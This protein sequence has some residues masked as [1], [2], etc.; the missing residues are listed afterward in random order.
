MIFL[1]RDDLFGEERL[2]ELRATIGTPDVQSLN[3][4]NLDGARLTVGE[5][6]T[7]VETFPFLSERRL[8]IVR[9]LFGA[10]SRGDADGEG[11]TRRG[12][13]DAEREREFLAYIPLVPPF[14]DLVLVV[15]RDVKT[16]HPV[17]K[18]VREAHGEVH[19]VDTPVG[20]A[21]GEWIQNRVRSK[22]GRVD[23]AAIAELASITVDDLRELDQT[24]ESLAIYAAERPIAV[25]DVRA[26]VRRS[27]ESSVF[28]RTR[29]SPRAT[30]LPLL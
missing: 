13:V 25:E 1:I 2:A 17:A 7:V 27:R 24:L 14:T 20:D 18:A 22:G 6:R 5:L 11:D 23:S 26:L 10:A 30:T 16:N 4:A 8:V 21:L 9:K 15:D 12:R 28:T 3:V 19:F 29:R